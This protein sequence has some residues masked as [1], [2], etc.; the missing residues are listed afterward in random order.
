MNVNTGFISQVTIIKKQI[1][2]DY[3]YGLVGVHGKY[4]FYQLLS[5]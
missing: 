3:M 5:L 2:M 4:N 1:E